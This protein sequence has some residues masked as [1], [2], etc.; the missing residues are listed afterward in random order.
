METPRAD[1][2]SLTCCMRT[3]ESEVSVWMRG[4]DPQWAV[5]PMTML[6]VDSKFKII[7]FYVSK[8]WFDIFHIRNFSM[9]W[10]VVHSVSRGQFN[11]Y[12]IEK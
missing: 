11:R 7:A 10:N 4:P 12:M 1:H 6:Y 3:S 5:D 2:T 8:Y 9:F